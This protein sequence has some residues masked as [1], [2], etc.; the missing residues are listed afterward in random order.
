M[1]FL[2]NIAHCSSILVSDS[3]FQKVVSIFKAPFAFATFCSQFCKKKK[4]TE[5]ETSF[6]LLT[7]LEKNTLSVI[8]LLPD[9]SLS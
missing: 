8:S 1:A 5:V 4:K 6:L 9:N 2:G 7:A 3:D